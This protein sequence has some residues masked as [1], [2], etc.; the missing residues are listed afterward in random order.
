MGIFE[1]AVLIKAE[2]ER[3]QN[4]RPVSL[5]PL[6]LCIMEKIPIQASARPLFI[7][8]LLETHQRGFSSERSC[9]I[10]LLS[11]LGDLAIWVDKGRGVDVWNL[12]TWFGWPCTFGQAG[13]LRVQASLTEWVVISEN[14]KSHR[15]SLGWQI[16]PRLSHKMGNY[17][18]QS[19][20]MDM[21]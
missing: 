4:H 5:L 3:R 8:N 6:V 12:N 18:F 2:L 20:A 13:W 19:A 17:K 1:S 21:I 7:D 16:P 10:Y 14:L 9:L 11:S 15:Q